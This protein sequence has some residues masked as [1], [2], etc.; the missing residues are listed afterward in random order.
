MFFFLVSFY[1]K[2][3]KKEYNEYFYFLNLLLLINLILPILSEHY[4]FDNIVG[5][6]Q[7]FFF[8]AVILSLKKIKY[9]E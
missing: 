6:Y 3:R 7:L 1:K 5:S 4:L 8:L 9:K 2:I